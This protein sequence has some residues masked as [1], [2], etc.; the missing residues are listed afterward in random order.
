MILLLID[1][2]VDTNDNS[3]LHK[4]S[5]LFIEST[6]LKCYFL[7]FAGSW[8]ESNFWKTNKVFETKSKKNLLENLN[9]YLKTKAKVQV[10]MN[11]TNFKVTSMQQVFDQVL[12]KAT[13]LK[14]TIAYSEII[15][16]VPRKALPSNPASSLKLKDFSQ[17]LIFENYLG[18]IL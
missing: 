3:Q 4:F 7:H 18:E 12:N 11:L 13:T 6:L 16:L 10:S 15:G 5:N 8:P 14:V 2:S 9:K 1:L 17:N